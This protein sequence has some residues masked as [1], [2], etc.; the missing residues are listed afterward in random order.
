MD[1]L[2]TS[3]VLFLIVRAVKESAYC[4]V[5]AFGK[6]HQFWITVSWITVSFKNFSQ[7]IRTLLVKYLKIIEVMY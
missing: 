5:L 4:R 3:G 2:G 1:F 7:I 6:R